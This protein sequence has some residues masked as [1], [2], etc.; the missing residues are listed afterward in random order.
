MMWL[1]A[2][3]PPIVSFFGA[4][5]TTWRHPKRET[6]GAIQ[7]FAAGVVF[8]AAAGEILPDAMHKGAIW[9]IILGGAVGI[10][11]MLSIRRLA[12]SAKEQP[13]GLIA[14]SAL[15]ALIDGLVLGLGF[16]VGRKQGTLLAIVLAIEFLFLGLSISGAFR[17]QSSRA[18]QP[19]SFSLSRSAC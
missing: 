1:H 6:I 18:A 2:F 12:E 14:V 17:R 16:N 13:T 7:H 19:A 15:D 11:T 4:T 8:H 3:I 9:T 10:A 5:W